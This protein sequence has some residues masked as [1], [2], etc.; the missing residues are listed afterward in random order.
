MV[1]V[2]LIPEVGLWPRLAGKWFVILRERGP[3]LMRRAGIS[4]PFFD[5]LIVTVS[6]F[7]LPTL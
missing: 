6:V 1:F 4:Y 3:S 7:S 2:W 5:Y